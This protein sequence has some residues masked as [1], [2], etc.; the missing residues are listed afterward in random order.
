M[1]FVPRHCPGF[2]PQSR[3]RQ[4]WSGGTGEFDAGAGTKRHVSGSVGQ[5]LTAGNEVFHGNE[6]TKI[7]SLQGLSHAG[8]A[9][10]RRRGVTVAP[11]STM[12]RPIFSNVTTPL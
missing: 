5:R 12:L 2:L 11:D 4:G 6:N 10:S 1:R 9:R 8:V 3:Q 7:Y